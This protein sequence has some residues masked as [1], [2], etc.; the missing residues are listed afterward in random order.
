M[1]HRAKKREKKTCKTIG[2]PSKVKKTRKK[3]P[4]FPFVFSPEPRPENLKADT[5]H[6]ALALVKKR[7]RA[8][9]LFQLLLSKK[10]L[11]QI[12]MKKQFNEHEV[13]II[14]KGV[15]QDF[16]KPPGSDQ[17]FP[18]ARAQRLKEEW[19]DWMLKGRDSRDDHAAD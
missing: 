13:G 3:A 2:G 11:C 8:S 18:K 17:D 19:C 12:S 9:T 4:A 16:Q 15:F 1:L 7:E 5:T 6:G 14:A 10:A